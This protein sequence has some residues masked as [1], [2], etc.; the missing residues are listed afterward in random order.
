[1]TYKDGIKKA[2]EIVFFEEPKG[3]FDTGEVH[4]RV[5]LRKEILEKLRREL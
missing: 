3:S 1:M 2:I 4:A 5:E